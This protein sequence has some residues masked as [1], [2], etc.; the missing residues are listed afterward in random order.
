MKKQLIALS[1]IIMFNSN[2]HA[3]DDKSMTTRAGKLN[4]VGDFQQENIIFKGRKL[5]KE[6]GSY[7]FTQKFTFSDRDVILTSSS[8]GASC[9][10]WTFLTANNKGVYQS[11]IFGT[12]D[13]GPKVTKDGEKIILIMNNKKN[14][15]IRY[16][17]E[18]NYL[19][20]NGKSI[21]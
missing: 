5:F 3:D 11:P 15:K 17:F 6:D 10:L 13:D 18:N 1:I 12:C 7:G 8:E 2:A 19:L 4:I 9:Q 21:K 16:T 20:E 14:K